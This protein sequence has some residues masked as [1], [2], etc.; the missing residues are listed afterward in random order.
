[1]ARYPTQDALEAQVRSA[2][3]RGEFDD[4]PGHGKP[5]QLDDLDHLPSEQRLAALL[6]RSMREVPVAVALV[7]EIRALRG[8][9]EASDS[10]PERARALGLLQSKL[11]ELNTA[12]KLERL[13]G[14]QRAQ[15]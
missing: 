2:R 1:M 8:V 6:M 14:K 4:L 9:I 11:T 13:S 10:E 5:L 15:E 7:R 12:L 3:E